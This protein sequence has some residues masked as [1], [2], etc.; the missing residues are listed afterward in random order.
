MKGKSRGRLPRANKPLTIP[1]DDMC[2]TLQEDKEFQEPVISLGRFEPT[3]GII[4]NGNASVGSNSL[5][6][7]L[8]D[9]EDDSPEQDDD[10]SA[11][12]D[13]TYMPDFGGDFRRSGPL[14]NPYENQFDGGFNSFAQSRVI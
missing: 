12:T 14:Y 1:E 7:V 3:G 6:S 4:D 5:Q 9:A 2:E 13:P 10:C 11:L 8:E